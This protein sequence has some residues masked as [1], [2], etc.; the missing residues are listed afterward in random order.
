MTTKHYKDLKAVDALKRAQSI[1]VAPFIFEATVAMK[2]LGILKALIKYSEEQGITKEALA[3]KCNLPSYAVS[4]LVDL[5]ITADLIICN[6]RNELSLS[7][8]GYYLATDTMTNI[9]L[10]FSHDVC[11]QG[12]FYLTESLKSG[13]AEGLKVFTDQEETIYPFLGKL[14][15][16]AKSSWFAFDHFYSNHVFDDLLNKLYSD[17]QIRNIYD[18][19]GNTGI[20]A[21]R[22][23]ELK[24]D[25]RVTI[26]DLESQCEQ[27]KE[28]IKGLEKRIK[29]YPI[30]ILDPNQALPA[31]SK[32]VDLWW[33]SQFLDCFSENQIETIFTK[34][35]QAMGDESRVVITEIFADRQTNDT[36][37]LI[38][39]A[40]SLYFTA[41]ANGYSKFYHYEDLIK[42][43]QKVGFTLE[44]EIHQIGLG[45]SVLILKKQ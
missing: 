10:D 30:N 22:A 21:K 17:Y 19:G 15:P 11:Y 45:H 34:I 31:S 12:L 29:V 13:K 6:D 41:L 25:V 18:L 4:M 3:Q 26:L 44:K 20:F 9:N 16:A 32:T 28:N 39:D 43:T 35:H 1:A 8:I 5:G 2:K 42:L 7:K 36:A 14:P 38:V 33:M 27:A 40:T 23:T 24:Q 37:S